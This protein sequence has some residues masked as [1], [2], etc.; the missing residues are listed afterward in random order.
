MSPRCQRTDSVHRNK[1]P[2][3][4]AISSKYSRAPL[5]VTDTMK[6]MPIDITHIGTMNVRNEGEPKTCPTLTRA[7]PGNKVTMPLARLPAIP[8]FATKRLA[9]RVCTVEELRRYIAG[10]DARSELEE[11]DSLLAVALEVRRKLQQ[12]G[13]SKTSE[14]DVIADVSSRALGWLVRLSRPIRPIWQPN[15]FGS[16]AYV[17]WSNLQDICCINRCRTMQSYVQAALG[18]YPATAPR[19]SPLYSNGAHDSKATGN[20]NWHAMPITNDTAAAE[21]SSLV[22]AWSALSFSPDRGL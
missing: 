10:C 7:A 3:P 5:A 14:R 4:P 2:P 22:K 21:R 18:M 6:T 11:V 1:V 8:H 20:G 12:K 16:A 19:A 13:R 17:E 15:H 9:H